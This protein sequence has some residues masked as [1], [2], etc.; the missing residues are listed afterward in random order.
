MNEMDLARLIAAGE[1]PSPSPFGTSYL[2]ALRV[3][4]T[5]LADRPSLNERV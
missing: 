5:G 3:S 2:V 1:A 4:G